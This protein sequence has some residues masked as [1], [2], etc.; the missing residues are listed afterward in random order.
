MT[1]PGLPHPGGA[2]W[3]DPPPTWGTLASW[4]LTTATSQPEAHL[5]Q[6]SPAGHHL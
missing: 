4:G 3:Q 2:S 5:D 1:Q 6:A